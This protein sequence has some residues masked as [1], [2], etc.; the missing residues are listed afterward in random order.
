MKSKVFSVYDSK[1]EAYLPPFM[2]PT[3]GMALRA[4]EECASS[5]DHQFCKHAADYTLFELGE[6][7][8]SKGTYSQSTNHVN[9]G[10]LIEFKSK[11]DNTGNLETL[12]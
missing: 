8:D 2:M 9:L 12:R 5:P 4:M 10:C 11:V 3:K 1:A 7:D 6:F